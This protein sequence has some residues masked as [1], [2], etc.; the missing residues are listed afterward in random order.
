MYGC[1]W[2]PAEKVDNYGARSFVENTPARDEGG[3]KPTE[4]HL[5][6]LH[7]RKELHLISCEE[8]QFLEVKQQAEDRYDLFDGILVS[9]VGIAEKM[10]TL[11]LSMR[12]LS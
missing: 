8:Q 11:A 2:V 4:L 1:P 12:F 3:F 9:R 5:R 6:D 7:H 10:I